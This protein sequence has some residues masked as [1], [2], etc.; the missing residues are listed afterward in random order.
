M[1]RKAISGI[2]L[3]L[4]LVGILN[5]PPTVEA[6][7][8]DPKNQ[9]FNGDDVEPFVGEDLWNFS[10][11]IEWSRFAYVNDN[12]AEVVI[13]LSNAQT[14]GCDRLSSLTYESCGEIVNTVSMGRE[15]VALVVNMSV[16]TV[17]SFVES[18]RATGLT[19]Y[20]EPNIRFQ[21]QLTPNDPYW[22]SQWGPRKIE[23]D[24][25]WN[26]TVGD[27]SVL[28]AVID[29]GIDYNHLDLVD[30]YVALGYDWVNNDTDPMDDHGHGTHCAGIIAATIN[31]GI[32]IAGMAQVRIMAE[33]GLN[34]GGSGSASDLA[35]AII[36]AVD[37]G[38]DILSN[39]WGSFFYSNLI[40]DAVGYARDHG[41][42][43]VAAAGNDASSMKHYPAAY[44]EVVAVT[45]TDQ[46]DD[47]ASFTS[48]GKW[49]DVAAP[50]VDIYSTYLNNGYEYKGGTSM[51]CPHAA[52]VAALIWSE[53]PSLTRDEVRLRLQLTA[54]DLGDSGFDVYYGYGR[55][56]AR[57]AVEPLP[58][59]DLLILN[60][61]RP[62]YVE[63]GSS[64]M[65]N[66][67]VVNFGSNKE[68]GI[69]VQL[70]VNGSTV[71]SAY[72]S[73]LESMKSATVS[74]S[75]N[76]A[77]EGRYYMESYVVPVSGE[78]VVE[79]NVR[80]A[81]INVRVGKFI[82]V[83]EDCSRIQEAAGL[84]SPGE[85]IKVASGTYYEHV[86]IDI[87][88]KLVGEDRN[89]TVIDGNG[90]GA[91]VGVTADNVEVR[92]F[93]VQ[94]SGRGLPRGGIVL[95][96]VKNCVVTNNTLI[97]DFEGVLLWECNGNNSV[98]GNT[99]FSIEDAGVGSVW[100]AGRDTV[101]D[102]VMTGGQF[103]VAIVGWP[104]D[105]SEYNCENTVSRNMI[106]NSEY[107]I[108]ICADNNTVVNN[109]ITLCSDRGIWL[110]FSNNTIRDNGVKNN[111]WGILVDF[112]SSNKIHHND[113]V[114]NTIQVY[115]FGSGAQNSWDDGYPSGGNHWSDYDGV[116]ANHDGIGDTPYVLNENNRDNYPLMHPL[117][118]SFYGPAAKFKYSPET[119]GV[120]ETVTF[121]A[122]ASSPG[123]N[124]TA[125]VPITYMWDFDDGNITTVTNLV[126]FHVFMAE[127]V[128]TVNL[129][130]A[131]DDSVLLEEGFASDST[132]QD[133]PVT[134]T[135]C[136]IRADGSV[137][138]PTAPISSVD[139]FTYTFTG[140]INMSI[141]VQRDNIVIDGVGYTLQGTLTYDS[142]GIDLTERSNVTIKNMK[143]EAFSCGI[144][145]EHSSNNSIH[146]NN[147]TANNDGIYLWDSSNNTISENN[148]TDNGVL[149]EGSGDGIRLWYYSSYN[150]ISGNNIKT[151]N[152]HGIELYRASNNF[153]YHNN[154]K[155]NKIQVYAEDSVN[156]WDD[157]YPSGGNYWSEHNPSDI[158]SGPIQ[159]ETG[160]DGIGDTPYII[161]ENNTD[162]YP[163]IYPYDYVPSPD[164]NDNGIIDIVDIVTCALAFGS[165]PGN[166]NWNPIADVNQDGII[167][168]VDIV[169][170]A[171]HFGEIYP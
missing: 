23:A 15:T 78:T 108:G 26:T 27:P 82:R 75:W 99:A 70:Q 69:T 112:A 7:V 41:V 95:M 16:K 54:D 101:S 113:F 114:H 76:P 3:A 123:W 49:V 34:S 138:P 32:G 133:V 8:N 36:H 60:W 11:M 72:I 151:N 4:I 167:D 162:R 124:G 102:N 141:V 12:S 115:F 98:Y 166:P 132:W 164:V 89:T 71:D 159:N 47:P 136:I 6:G 105:P 44:D 42:L 25:A 48:Y 56:N 161:N 103:G 17:S 153:I 79:N 119:P 77:V 93:T 144:W 121:N 61:K 50:G 58:S 86:C 39:S 18:V 126:I 68:V 21:T 122:S 20:V 62:A 134:F 118:T 106:S 65:V 52:G 146:G 163:L 30:N 13:G 87:S 14:E 158:N 137:F 165:K 155:N 110:L 83:P 169:M 66:T 85:T 111:E 45:A 157:G 149:Y 43:V 96:G 51:A 156:V 91:V 64:G 100:S 128:Y 24:D 127:G 84:A 97:N 171:L 117:V 2:M 131:C 9:N 104:T 154:F 116:D 40:H 29:T 142:K 46:S 130:V 5:I 35:D 160:R 147:I 28:V 53:F 92:R 88:L 31:N 55:V 81:Y 107:G 74:C 22:S 152:D 150:T 109:N 125:R 59:H 143:I 10:N 1:E 33:K 38:A 37:Q 145:L 63:P 73:D 148:I 80:S 140:D 19:K 135:V 168:I 120:Y 170:I 57:R 139:N 90:T 67:T 94:N 129:T